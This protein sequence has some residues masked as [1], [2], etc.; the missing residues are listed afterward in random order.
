MKFIAFTNTAQT[1]V[2]YIDYAGQKNTISVILIATISDGN[3]SFASSS[4]N[5]QA[6]IPVAYMVLISTKIQ[7]INTVSHQGEHGISMFGNYNKIDF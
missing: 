7:Y 2:T 4:A 3:N 5:S 6:N 1:K